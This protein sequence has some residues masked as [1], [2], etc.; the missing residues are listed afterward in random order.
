MQPFF[1]ALTAQRDIAAFAR[2]NNLKFRDKSMAFQFSLPKFE[3]A[4][5]IQI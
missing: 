4:R 2:L 1:I 3:T 5:M